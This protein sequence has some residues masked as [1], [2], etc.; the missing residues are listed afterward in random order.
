MSVFSIEVP[1]GHVVDIEAADQATAVRGA[2]EWFEQ[3]TALPETAQ[4]TADKPPGMGML[5]SFGRGALSGATLGGADEAAQMFGA[6]PETVEGLRSNEKRARTD[7]PV[8]YYAGQALGGVAPFLIPGVGAVRGATVGARA[9][10]AGLKGIGIGAASGALSAEPGERLTG[11]AEGAALGGATAAVIP[12]LAAGARAI[13][14]GVQDVAR[15]LRGEP[16]ALLNAP[17]APAAPFRGLAAQGNTAMPPTNA[18][19]VTSANRLGVSVPVFMASDN[20]ATQ[21]L[22]EGIRNIPGAGG[23]IRAEA[24]R[25]P[26]GLGRAAD[27]VAETMR[28]GIPGATATSRAS[29]AVAGR[30]VSDGLTHWISNESQTRVSAAYEAVDRAITQAGQAGLTG[31]ARTLSPLTSTTRA[32]AALTRQNN[33][34]ALPPGGTVSMLEDAVQRPNGLTYQGVKLLR[35]RIG[36]MI[37][38]PNIMR[39]DLSQTELRSVYGALSR[40]LQRAAGNAGG[41]QARSLFNQANTLSRE[42]FA[43]RNA[44]S[45][46]VGVGGDATGEQVYA[47]VAA[48]ASSGA[49]GDVQK[50]IQVR[51]TLGRHGQGA[52]QEFQGA[53]VSGLGREAPQGTGPLAIGGF[54]PAK[55]VTAWGKIPENAKQ[56]M[57]AGDP[58]WRRALNDIARVSL[59]MRDRIQRFSNPSGTAQSLVGAGTVAG[60]VSEPI[61]TITGIIGARAMANAL[62]RPATTQMV[63]QWTHLAAQH[64]QRPTAATQALMHGIEQRLAAYTSGEGGMALGAPGL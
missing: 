39:G 49:R 46:I 63:A 25:L 26:E 52:W 9:L 1:S 19:V 35:G 36:E 44:L 64:A 38:S 61:S 50:L 40:D 59:G 12:P 17:A 54:S 2:Q 58:E 37:D 14:T 13:G 7:A 60:L 22:A 27:T 15:T 30:E 43:T 42:T 55:F 18:E 53:I 8:S 48:L 3:Q 21:Q 62:S 28:A 4:P 20:R 51:D 10:N 16:T 24:D 57:F 34:A 32:V 11:A 31:G 23:I 47:R 6:S 56:V 33:A 41:P 29:A 45:S 5:E